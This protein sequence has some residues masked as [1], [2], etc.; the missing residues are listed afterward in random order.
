[1]SS[2]IIK[3]DPFWLN[4]FTILIQKS[5]L[6]EFFP[7]DDMTLNEKMNA[8]TRLM[9]Y[10]S[11]VLIV[12]TRNIEYIFLFVITCIVTILLNKYFKSQEVYSENNKIQEGFEDLKQND[13]DNWV[14]PTKE[15]PF[16]NVSLL[17]YKDNPQRNSENIKDIYTIN[18]EK[19]EYLNKDIEQK[20]NF[21]LYRDV[22]D[23]FGKNNSQ[24]EFYTAPVTTIPNNQGD[25][26]DWCY[27]T[28]KTCKENNGKQCLENISFQPNR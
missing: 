13:G 24:R 22:S 14:K 26:A 19:K 6:V 8:T 5:R 21:N 18:N 27:K 25:F 10:I 9:F 1:M 28:G 3:S 2:Q 23:V 11:I 12:Y 16:M 7:T 17:D 15:N 4:D 20:F